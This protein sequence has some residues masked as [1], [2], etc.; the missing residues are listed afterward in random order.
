MTK[1]FRAY[2]GHIQLLVSQFKRHEILPPKHRM[3]F[4]KLFTIWLL[5]K[6]RT[7]F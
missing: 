3:R 7:P 6:N 4:V 2:L 1:I 5:E